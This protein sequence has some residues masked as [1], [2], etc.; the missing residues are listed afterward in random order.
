MSAGAVFTAG[1][2]NGHR[3]PDDADGLIRS[4][5]AETPDQ[6]KPTRRVPVTRRV[7]AELDRAGN[8][9]FV[10]AYL[11]RWGYPGPRIGFPEGRTYIELAQAVYECPSQPSPR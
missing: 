7:I 6:P 11:G 3:G 1:R 2:E 10:P 8:L 9:P 5:R 4:T